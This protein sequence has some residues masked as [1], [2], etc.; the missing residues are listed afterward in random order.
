MVD[1]P[2]PNFAQKRVLRPDLDPGEAA[3]I[4][5][6]LV[7]PSV[8]DRFVHQ[9]GWSQQRFTDWLHQTMLTQLLIPRTEATRRAATTKPATGAGRR[10][11]SSR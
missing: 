11:R 6:L 3:D 9:Y 7:D 1:G 8:Y 4:L 10:R 2:V 5:A